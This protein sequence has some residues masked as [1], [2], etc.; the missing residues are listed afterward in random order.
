MTEKLFRVHFYNN[1]SKESR[2]LLTVL[3]IGKRQC[4][5]KSC[6]NENLSAQKKLD[7]SHFDKVIVILLFSGHIHS[8][9]LINFNNLYMIPVLQQWTMIIESNLIIYTFCEFDCLTLYVCRFLYACNLKWQ[10]INILSSKNDIVTGKC[11][12]K[13]NKFVKTKIFCY[14]NRY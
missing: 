1:F 6:C 8:S 2:I 3:I 13:L 7:I 11:N 12:R 5:L 14:K 9:S 10:K 4:T